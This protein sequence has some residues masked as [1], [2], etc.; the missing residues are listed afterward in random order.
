[1]LYAALDTETTGLLAPDHRIIEVYIGLYKNG[2]KVWEF[3]QRIDPQ[4]SIGAEA[5]RVHGISASDLYGKPTFDAVASV[6][7]GALDRA[8][9]FVWHNGDEFDGPFL[10]QELR[11]VGLPGMPQKP[12]IDTML[13]GVWATPDGKKPRLG[14]LCFACGVDYDT[15]K[16]HAASYDVDVMMECFMRGQ[17]WGFFKLPSDEEGLSRAA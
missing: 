13:H 9:C 2:K 3:D 15:S 8:D 16:A 1:M 11:R 7:R 4:R 17:K 10:D 6:I 5:Q 14:E 12:S